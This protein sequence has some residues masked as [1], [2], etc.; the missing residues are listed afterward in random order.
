VKIENHKFYKIR[1]IPTGLYKAPGHNGRFNSTGKIWLG[2]R[3]KT[4][5]RMFEDYAVRQGRA[6]LVD[7][8][9]RD[10]VRDKQQFRLDDCEVV[11]YVMTE[12]N[13]QHLREFIETEMR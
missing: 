1:H 4:H 6:V 9:D 13:T 8:I 10:W 5:L 7:S 12:T 11:E 3:L 2:A